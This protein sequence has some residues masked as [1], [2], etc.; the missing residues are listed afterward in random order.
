MLTPFFQ[1]I[2]HIRALKYEDTR[3]RRDV[4][5]LRGSTEYGRQ[6]EE[7][8]KAIKN[9]LATCYQHLQRVEPNNHHVF[10]SFTNQ[11]AVNPSQH[12]APPNDPATQAQA[13][14]H[15]LSATHV[16][17]ASGSYSGSAAAA[18]PMVGVQSGYQSAGPSF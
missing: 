12:A 2:E 8:N 15:A 14:L 17:A 6:L 1:A 13:R 3:L 4:E 7:E 5:Q 10:G 18:D 11:L 9:E 16:P